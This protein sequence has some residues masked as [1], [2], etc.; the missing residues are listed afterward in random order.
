MDKLNRNNKW[1]CVEAN[2][3][4]NSMLLCVVKLQLPLELIHI[5]SVYL[6][7]PANATS[8]TQELLAAF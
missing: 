1:H 6:K 2:Q 4:K 8:F 3:I 7:H 5:R